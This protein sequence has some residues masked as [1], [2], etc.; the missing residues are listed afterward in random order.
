[1]LREAACVN[2]WNWHGD[3]LLVM[4]L[5]ATS[6]RGDRQLSYGNCTGESKVGAGGVKWVGEN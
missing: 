1:M 3:D 2:L 5:P 4:L 6:H